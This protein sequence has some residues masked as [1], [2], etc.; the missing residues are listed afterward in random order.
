MEK[1]YAEGIV[2]DIVLGRY[3]L[4][5]TE[6]EESL[7]GSSRITC[8]IITGSPRSIQADHRDV[9]SADVKGS[10]IAPSG[11]MEKVIPLC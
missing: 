1:G 2:L 4:L 10:A 5:L 7:L 6:E 3:E 8:R 9:N 11:T